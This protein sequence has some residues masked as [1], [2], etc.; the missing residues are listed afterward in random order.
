MER[1]DLFILL[2]DPNF[3]GSISY[4]EFVLFF[5]REP[6]VEYI[7]CGKVGNMRRLRNIKFSSGSL[8]IPERYNTGCE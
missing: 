6:A 4:D 3:V 5:F 2:I 7:N 8:R 1:Y